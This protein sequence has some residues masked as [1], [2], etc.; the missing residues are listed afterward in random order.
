MSDSPS[1]SVCCNVDST[2]L[3]NAKILSEKWHLTCRFVPPDAAAKIYP[4]DSDILL[5][6]QDIL[7]ALINLKI[8]DEHTAIIMQ[9]NRD[10]GW[11]AQL[12]CVHAFGIDE[13]IPCGM[14]ASNLFNALIN[15]LEQPSNN[16]GINAKHALWRYQKLIFANDFP[17]RV[18]SLITPAHGVFS[19]CHCTALLAR[20]ARQ[21]HS[22]LLYLKNQHINWS[23]QFDNGALCTANTNLSEPFF[24]F[25]AWQMTQAT[26][27]HQKIST[28]NNDL[29]DEQNKL[30][31]AFLLDEVFSWLDA[32]FDWIPQN[33]ISP[34]QQQQTLSASELIDICKQN[35]L[36]AIPD[37]VIL[38]GTH[39]L[40]SYFLKLRDNND[41]CL[42]D[43]LS[44]KLKSVI[45]KLKVGDSFA[46]LLTTLP[47]DYK[48]QR[49]VYL[50]AMLD[51]LDW[52]P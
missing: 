44:L 42:A 10:M 48:V 16:S 52:K 5:T 35:A 25:N 14:C 36:H 21:R 7:P 17:N 26:S 30:W 20:I 40:L 31:L 39:S 3:R 2:L 50:A 46:E 13:I 34:Q 4:I 29:N 19:E 12:S 24:G 6:T 1:L 51:E 32:E 41:G 27:N 43:D 18:P 45:D 15:Q 11:A 38:D 28:E 47:D 22:G 8:L 23:F 9:I 37:A 33:P 49:V